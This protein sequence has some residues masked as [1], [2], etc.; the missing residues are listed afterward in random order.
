LVREVD[1]GLHAMCHHSLDD[2]HRRRLEKIADDD[3]P[4]PSSR[5]TSAAEPVQS[6]PPTSADAGRSLAH[7]RAELLEEGGGLP[8]RDQCLPLVGGLRGVAHNP[9]LDKHIAE[10]LRR[11][12]RCTR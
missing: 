7:P 2:E 11:R 9:K 12:F 3:F 6:V 8:G 4:P 5:S 10:R 1:N